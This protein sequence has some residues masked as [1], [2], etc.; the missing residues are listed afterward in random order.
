MKI[1]NYILS[2]F[3]LLLTFCVSAQSV[4]AP[5]KWRV[6]TSRPRE[7]DFEMFRGETVSL[8]PRFESFAEPLQLPSNAVIRLLYRSSDMAADTY[9]EITGA[10][11]TGDAGRVAVTWTPAADSGKSSYVYNLIVQSADQTQTLSRA[12]GVLKMKGTVFGDFGTPATVTNVW[13][14][15]ADLANPHGVT[16]AQTGAYTQA[17]VDAL[18]AAGAAVWGNITGTLSAQTDLQTVLDLKLE[19][20]DADPAG[21]AATVQTNLDTHE[22]DLANPHVVTKAQVGLGSADDTSDEDKPVSIAAQTALDLKLEQ[23]ESIG[24]PLLPNFFTL[25]SQVSYSDVVGSTTTNTVVDAV[26]ENWVTTFAKTDFQVLLKD[27]RFAD[28]D[29]VTWSSSAPAVATVSADGLAEYVSNGTA[30]ITGTLGTFSKTLDLVFTANAVNYTNLLSG[31]ATYL[32][33]DLTADIDAALTADAAANDDELFDTRNWTTHSYVR[34]ASAWAYAATDGSGPWTGLAVWA[35][36]KT[37]TALGQSIRGTLISPDTIAFAWH[38]RPAVGSQFK[39]LGTDSVVYTRT[40]LATV[41]LGSGDAGIGRLDSALPAEVVPVKILPLL[42]Q[43]ILTSGTRGLQFPVIAVNRNLQAMVADVFSM[44]GNTAVVVSSV[45]PLRLG[46]YQQQV[47]GD[48]GSPVLMVLDGELVL[49]M[50]W[51]TPFYGFNFLNHSSMQAAVIAL[52][53]TAPTLIDLSTYPESG[54]PAP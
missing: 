18:L 38:N 45:L 3:L 5:L 28:T 6:E 27:L 47:T 40:L 21:S 50:T 43:T 46:Y 42:D 35:T 31:V 7:V 44:D 26:Q 2:A 48:S 34:N 8:Q 39:Y 29:V 15:I 4:I 30:T 51:T 41:R 22:A 19:T 54:P 11:V 14:H 36:G 53:G 49:L 1:K 13:T 16:A 25:D 12:F 37:S 9:H 20:G 32:R 33:A 23:V 17:Q 10:L 24:G 52:G